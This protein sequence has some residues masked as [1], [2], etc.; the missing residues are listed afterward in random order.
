M[1]YLTRV[2]HEKILPGV[3][4]AAKVSYYVWSKFNADKKNFFFTFNFYS[5]VYLATSESLLEVGES[6]RVLAVAPF[7]HLKLNL[8]WTN[9][10]S[11]LSEQNW[12]WTSSTLRILGFTFHQHPN[13]FLPGN[14]NRKIS[15]GDICY[16]NR[17]PIPVSS[18]SQ[19][20]HGKVK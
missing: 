12:H 4:R 17:L 6:G 7:L 9:W 3:L 11:I 14:W 13:T 19:L 20:P 16:S 10:T 5:F 8:L 1:V 15:C 18:Y 2:E